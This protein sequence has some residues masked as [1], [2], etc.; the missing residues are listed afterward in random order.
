MVYRDGKRLISFLCKTQARDERSAE[1][2]VCTSCCPAWTR[3]HPLMKTI[4]ILKLVPRRFLHS[5]AGLDCSR[6][7][8][9]ALNDQLTPRILKTTSNTINVYPAMFNIHSFKWVSHL[10]TEETK[11]GDDAAFSSGTT[12]DQDAHAGAADTHSLSLC[13]LTSDLRKASFPHF[14]HLH[15]MLLLCVDKIRAVNARL[16]RVACAVA[17]KWLC[18]PWE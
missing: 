15:C 17:S 10:L 7:A 6:T 13:L 2:L 1:L 3:R 18:A 14:F 16:S 8:L 11:K 4:C 12:A 9:T 5:W